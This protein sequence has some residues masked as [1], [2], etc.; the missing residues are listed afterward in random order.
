MSE[1]AIIDQN[2]YAAMAKLTGMAFDSGDSKATLARLRVNKQPIMGETEVNG[3]KAKVEVVSAG[4]YVLVGTDGTKLYADNVSIRTFM[5]RFMYQKY[6]SGSKK[7][8]KTTM[9]TDL[10]SDLKDTTGGFNCGKPGGWIEDF[11][12]LSDGMK[13]VIRSVKRVR[14]IFGTL[15]MQG[16]T[17]S[18]DAQDVEDVPFIWE[19][20]S[21]EGFTNLGSVFNKLNTMKRLPI[22]HTMSVSTVERKLPT[23]NTYYVPDA[24]LDV[25]SNIEMTDT[26]QGVFQE[27]MSHVEGYNG[28]VL[29]EFDSNYKQDDVIEQESGGIADSFV[30]VNIE[31]EDE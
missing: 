28:W 8:I 24:E 21:K 17:E 30:N 7:Y 10:K 12:A 27:L 9:A 1:I 6:D 2:N 5:Q 25:K 23:G 14:V 13:E 4:S 16:V 19:V 31:E 15:S 18:G 29:K 3:K 11:N 22:N 26:D 20:D